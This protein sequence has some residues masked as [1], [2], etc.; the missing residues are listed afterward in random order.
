MTKPEPVWGIEC[1]RLI[2]TDGALIAFA[3]ITTWDGK[4]DFGNMTIQ[5]PD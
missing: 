4:Y 5:E 1:V 2:T 3:F